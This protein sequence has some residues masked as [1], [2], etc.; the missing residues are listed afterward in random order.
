MVINKL[1]AMGM[2]LRGKYSGDVKTH[3]PKCAS[4]R[5]KSGDPSLSVNV[6][7]G[8]W[9]CH[10]C[11]WTGSVNQYVRPEAKKPVETP[12][13]FKF[14][15]KRG[16]DRATVEYFRVSESMEWMPQ[17][18]KEHKVICFN[19]YLGGELIN[20]KFKTAD[21]KFKMVKDA[22]KTAFNIDA[23]KNS[24]YA[25]ICE[26]EEEV[27]VWHQSGLKAVSV[28]NGAS[29]NNN[30]LDWLNAVYDDYFDGK[31]IYIATDN[32]EPGRK[33]KDDL[34]RRFSDQDIYL[35]EFPEGQ[36]DANDCLLAYGQEFLTRLYSDAKPAPMED[37][38]TSSDYE[39]IVL[40]Y[41]KDGYPVGDTVGMINTD[42]HHTWSRGELGVV[43]GIPGCF[44][45]YQLV[46]TNRGVVPISEIVVGDLV[47][48]YNETRNVNEWKRVV[49]TPVHP[50]TSD[51]MFKITMKDGTVIKVTENHE[52]YHQG[53]FVKIKDLLVQR[54]GKTKIN[55]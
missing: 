39:S 4:T 12:A 38:S 33:L 13:I 23:I 37:V 44:D 21:K 11:G 1:I 9:K 3:C 14:F 46:H 36:K 20:I 52:F 54:F 27:M 51:R 6:D 35:I 2:D 34:I 49:A 10:H 47:L 25:I 19:Y 18:Q 53:E 5:K 31:K 15:E 22:Q 8:V 29:K 40:S 30:N 45:R 32:D 26:G 28:P 42:E 41:L 7:T 48:S 24:E 50:T 55:T 16:I 17:D 43:S